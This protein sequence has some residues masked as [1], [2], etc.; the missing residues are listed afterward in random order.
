MS[1]PVPRLLAAAAAAR[2]LKAFW[3]AAAQILSEQWGGV[4]VRFTYAGLRESGTVL[5]GHG[6][7]GPLR[8][9]EWVDA[10][11]RRVQLAVATDRDLSPPPEGLTEIVGNLALMV[12]QRLSLERDRRLGTFLIELSRW[13]LAAPERDVMLRYTMQSVMSLVDAQGA[14]VALREPKGRGQEDTLRVVT[15]IGTGVE[16]N[17]VEL[18]LGASVTGRVVRTGQPVNTEHIL[19]EPDS[20]TPADLSRAARAAMIVPLRTSAGVV[21]AAGVVRYLQLG[22]Q[23]PPPPFGL[24]ELHYFTAVAAHI[25]GAS[26]SP[27]QWRRRGRPRRARPRW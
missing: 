12:A 26:S 1:D 18:P 17:G 11:G 13:L 9:S 19:A 21:G 5:A 3:Q 8:E 4:R 10:E 2:T 20:H 16:M 15:A 27:R 7:A 23:E 6:A 25:A 22:M 24:V 14:Y